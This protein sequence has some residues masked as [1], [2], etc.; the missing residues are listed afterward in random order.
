[1]MIALHRGAA[2]MAHTEHAED[3]YGPARHLPAS[4]AS[5]RT[6]EIARMRTPLSA[7]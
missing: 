1:M 4:I 7:H 3:N 2:A 6:A 5:S